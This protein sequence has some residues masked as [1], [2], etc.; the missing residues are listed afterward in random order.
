MTAAE[1]VA[2]GGVVGGIVSQVLNFAIVR[3]KASRQSD[4]DEKKLELDWQKE[5]ND[6]TSNFRA[7]LHDTIKDLRQEVADLRNDVDRL[8]KEKLDLEE[9]VTR[10]RGKNEEQAREINRLTKQ[11][12]FLESE[13]EKLEVRVKELERIQKGG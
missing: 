4:T 12:T 6:A 5:F 11:N 7:E 3:Y 1:L 2:V 10:L 13:R 9:D 8:R